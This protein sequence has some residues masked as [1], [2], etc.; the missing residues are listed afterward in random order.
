MQRLDQKFATI[1]MARFE[2]LADDVTPQWGTM[3]RGQLFGH[4]DSVLRYTLGERDEMPFRGN[5]KTR[6]IFR[7]V[8]L[9]GLREIPHNITAP[10]PKGVSKEVLFPDIELPVLSSTIDEYL[11]GIDGGA[12]PTRI[13][14]FF[15]PLTSA[16]WQ[17]FHR[18]HFVHHMKQFNVGEGL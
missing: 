16:Q 12:L 5:F 4:L 11:K 13:H 9:L 1:A 10:I 8:I 15:G 14:P 2:S 3:T 6:H 17:R 7:H 18:L